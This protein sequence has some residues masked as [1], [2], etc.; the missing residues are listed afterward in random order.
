VIWEQQFGALIGL[1]GDEW[2][3]AHKRLEQEWLAAY[4]AAFVGTASRA[5]S[6]RE[7]AETWS[8]GVGDEPLAENHPGRPNRASPQRFPHGSKSPGNRVR[9]E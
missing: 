9:I 3:A 8:V 6:P 1:D 7:D 2:D 5:Y 4:T